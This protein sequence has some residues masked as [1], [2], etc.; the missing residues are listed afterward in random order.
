MLLSVCA[1]LAS[2]LFP[3]SLGRVANS[4][5][6]AGDRPLMPQERIVW[7]AEVWDLISTLILNAYV[8]SKVVAN[9]LQTW[10]LDG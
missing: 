3:E 10:S 1:H 2:Y 5:K 4:F 8:N 9:S 7:Q 6:A